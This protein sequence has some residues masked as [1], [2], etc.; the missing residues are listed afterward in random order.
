M[1]N[2]PPGFNLILIYFVYGLAFFSMGVVLA[3]ETGRS[4][5]LAERRVLRPLAV[6]GL[7][8]GSYVWLELFLIQARWFDVP[9]PAT[10]AWLRVGLL[11]FSFIPLVLFGFLGL[12]RDHML[13]Y[14]EMY[15]VGL[16][17]LFC[18]FLGALSYFTH[19]PTGAALSRYFLAVPGAA[20]ASS[21]L[22]IRSKSLAKEGRIQISRCFLLVSFGF[23]LFGF[24][25]LF[26]AQANFFP[27]ALIN[28]AFFLRVFGLPVQVVRSGAAVLIT[29]YLIRA[30]QLAERE[31]T[32]QLL[33]FRKERLNAMERVQ[34]ELVFREA[35][36]REL[37]RHIVIAQED[38]RSRI[39][40]ELHDETAQILTAFSLELAT[41]RTLNSKRKSELQI[42]DRLLNLSRQMSQGLYRLMHDLRPAQLDDLG[43][44]PAL[45]HLMDESRHRMQLQVSMV[46][47]GS[48]KR[49]DPLLETVIF[50]V[51]Q[52]SLTNVK[53]HAKTLSAQIELTYESERV[54][55]EIRDQGVGFDPHEEHLPP[56]GWGLA[57]MRERAGSVEGTLEILSSPGQGTVIQMIIPL[58]SRK[59]VS[60]E[61]VTHGSSR[62]PLN[63][64]G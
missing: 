32:E 29:I 46:V 40:R 55:L 23:G 52:E 16:L 26:V 58:S 9:I 33:A 17:I 49:L 7:L 34:Q 62:Y 28:D 11:A 5:R 45:Q 8:H 57:G 31:R 20:L 12:N 56:H 63:V 4:P 43:L 54:I 64:G 50:R 21:A 41:L 61:E 24:S 1:E 39:S 22:M 59:S 37:L 42:L 30:I 25:Q 44:V 38:E 47:H 19:L 48:R 14:F 53:R 35:M 36:R 15:I 13:K 60:V 3:L 6:F 51:A 18:L 27:A 2:F 10:F